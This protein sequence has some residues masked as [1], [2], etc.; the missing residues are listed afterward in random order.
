MF[1]PTRLGNDGL[2]KTPHRLFIER[3]GIA[4]ND[5]HQ[6]LHFARWDVHRQPLCVF[7]VRN[8][9]DQFGTPIQQCQ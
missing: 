7:E 2:E 4:G 9:N 6:H 1:E 3:P 5:L 8:G